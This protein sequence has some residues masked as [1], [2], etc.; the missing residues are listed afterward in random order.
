[1]KNIKVL[2]AFFLTLIFISV[3]LEGKS[4]NLKES[5]LPID[6]VY[7]MYVND[8]LI[9][10]NLVPIAWWKTVLADAAG[11]VAGAA[12]LGQVAVIAGAVTGGVGAGVALGVGGVIGGAAASV[13]S[14]SMVAPSGNGN[15]VNE[16]LEHLLL[17]ENNEN[18]MNYVGVNHNKILYDYTT[19]YQE[20]NI[21][22]FYDFCIVNST[23]YN[24][25]TE[26]LLDKSVVNTIILETNNLNTTDGFINYI[27]DK[28]P[29]SVNKY[30]FRVELT[31]LLMN[32]DFNITD[33]A[34]FEQSTK[35]L[36][37]NIPEIDSWIIDSFFA[38]FRYSYV[39]WNHFG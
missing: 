36:N 18:P 20:F 38:T 37:T 23:K 4:C 21:D 8:A 17:A 7:T 22:E 27:I 29:E 10:K 14:S 16:Y 1:M 6:E 34:N 25:N 28:L 31:A 13:A 3:S 2:F 39:Y 30:Q 32:V 19:E 5:N 33:I 24:I 26:Y 35:V 11:A 9:E 15:T 12:A